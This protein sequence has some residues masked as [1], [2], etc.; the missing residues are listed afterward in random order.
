[1]TSCSCAV[2]NFLQIHR[3]P[4]LLFESK[5]FRNPVDNTCDRLRDGPEMT[6]EPLFLRWRNHLYRSPILS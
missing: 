5:V 2:H 3:T 6:H 1:L 4:F